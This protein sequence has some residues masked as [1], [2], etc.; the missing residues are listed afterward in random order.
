[1]SRSRRR[2]RSEAD[3]ITRCSYDGS[4]TLARRKLDDNASVVHT[5]DQIV[6]AEDLGAPTV[7]VVDGRR[8]KVQVEVPKLG[9][10]RDVVTLV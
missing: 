9:T 7:M 3:E 1:L 10:C 8:A 5:P 4:A 2:R 6:G